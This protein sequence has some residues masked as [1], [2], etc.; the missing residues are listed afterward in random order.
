MTVY[1]IECWDCKNKG[2]AA[3]YIGQ[4]RRP[5]RI[6]FN[7]HLGDARFRRPDTGLGEHTLAF[8]P[9]MD[10]TAINSNFSIEI[11]A[12]KHHE[13]DLRICE[14]ILIRE[15]N[16]SMNTMSRSWSL[17]KHVI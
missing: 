8:H 11:L 6:R 16:P 1:R 7:E 17:T 4:S 12:T 2:E 5:V 15:Q 13:A 3:V 10:N 14:S 9:E